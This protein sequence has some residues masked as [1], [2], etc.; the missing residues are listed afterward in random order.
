MSRRGSAGYRLVG[1]VCLFP[2]L[3]IIE[4]PLRAQESPFSPQQMEAL[5]KLASIPWEKGPTVGRIGSMAEIDVPDGFQFAGSDGAQTLLEAYGNPR[6]SSILAAMVPTAEGQD[7]TLIFKFDDIGYIK[8][9]DQESIDAQEILNGFND[10]IPAQNSQR[11]SLGLEEMISM[12]WAESPFY[13][14]TTKNLK[15]GL[16]LNFAS[17]KTVNYDIRLLGRRGVMEAT[18]L[19][20]PEAYKASLPAVEKLLSGYRFTEGNKYSE[21]KS[22][23]KVAAYGLTGLIAGGAAVAAMKSGLFAKLGL[24]FAKLG[25]G[26]ILIVV[27]VGAGIMSLIKKLF[28]GSRSS[29]AE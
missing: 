23:D 16:L 14:P 26:A 19:D 9:A 21:W 27:A 13:D 3:A 25:K 7:W 15:W 6:D 4:V 22:G 10:S 12:S 18:L 1:L 20:S 24:M 29:T 5:Q 28:G 2:V 17:G 11:R 8:D